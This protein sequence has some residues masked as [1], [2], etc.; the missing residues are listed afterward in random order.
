[1]FL[2]IHSSPFFFETQPTSFTPR[3]LCL[4][5]ETL[6]AIDPFYLVSMLGEVNLVPSLPGGSGRRPELLPGLPRERG[7]AGGGHDGDSLTL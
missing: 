1:M 5:E 2:L 3:Y 6:K 7:R 4:S